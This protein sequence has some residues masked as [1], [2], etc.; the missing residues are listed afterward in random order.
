MPVAAAIIQADR[1]AINLPLIVGGGIGSSAQMQVAYAAG[2]DML[3]MGTA[4]ENQN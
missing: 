1:K 2:A 4:F 3:V